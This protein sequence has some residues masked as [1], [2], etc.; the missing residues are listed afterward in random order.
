MIRFANQADGLRAARG[1]GARV[2]RLH[3]ASSSPTRTIAVTSGKGGVGKTQ[4]AAN[5]AVGLAQKGLKVVLL[6]ADLGLASLDLA[7]GLKPQFDLRSVLDGEK[8][9]DEILLEGPAGVHLVP[10]CPGR[11]EMANLNGTERAALANA[12][13]EVAKKFD[14]LVID[15]GAGIGGNAVTFASAADDVLLVTTPD[16]TA[17]RDA[18]AMAKVLNRRSGLERI[19]L[20]SNQVASEAEGLELH[21]RLDAIVRRFLTLELGYLGCIPR[22][23][24]VR[25]ACAAGEPFVL[26]SPSS[27]AARAT[28]GL[29]RRLGP[30]ASPRELC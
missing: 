21:S 11:Y 12:V 23:E 13:D 6:D 9:I 14:V 15:T 3:R 8:N 10:A 30:G 2:Y 27:V 22:D 20:V 4:I 19:H 5:L 16:P 18:Y 17:V 25:Q 26:R 29:V 24:S 7:L 28:E 1:E